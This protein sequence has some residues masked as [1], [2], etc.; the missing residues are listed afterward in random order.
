VSP[1]PLR[2][3]FTDVGGTLWPERLTVHPSDDECV[4]RLAGLLP[5]LDPPRTLAALRSALRD[6]DGSV[7]QDTH[8]ILRK[9]VQ[10]L[11]APCGDAD[12]VAIRRAL[13]RPAALTVPL[14]PGARDFLQI[15]RDHGLC[16]VVLSN[17]QVRGAAEYWRDF[18]DLGV[19]NLI[20]AVVTSLEVGYR[21]PHAAMFQ[22]ALREAGCQAD[23]CVMVGDS[24]VKDIEPALA[25]GMRAIR[26]AIEAPAP[27][28]SA[29]HAV[30]TNLADA[31]A[32]VA[33]WTKPGGE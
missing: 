16:C 19:A 11:G 33:V 29:A 17:V 2:A 14:F 18:H 24:E 32:T 31:G 13:C 30:A 15:V 10:R 6:D 22:A 23:E 20:D 4:S 8:T 25:L 7:V 12:V 3:V 28:A 9:A 26:V 5:T 27:S 1:R 21:K